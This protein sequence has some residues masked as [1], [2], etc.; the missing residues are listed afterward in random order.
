MMFLKLESWKKVY[1]FKETSI[2]EDDRLQET[3]IFEDDRLQELESILAF[4]RILCKPFGVKNLSPL[5]MRRTPLFI[6]F[7]C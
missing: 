7:S 2:F 3:S 4:E 6:K 1:I 5:Q